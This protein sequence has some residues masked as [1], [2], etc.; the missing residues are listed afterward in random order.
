MSIN[1][2]EGHDLCLVYN[3]GVNTE[4]E[5]GELTLPRTNERTVMCKYIVTFKV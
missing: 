3:E 4:R 5:G 1:F 2:S